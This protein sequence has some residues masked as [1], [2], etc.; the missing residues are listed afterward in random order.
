M[1]DGSRVAGRFLVA[2]ALWFTTGCGAAPH[3][4]V[5]SNAGIERTDLNALLAAYPLAPADIIRA[6]PLGRTEAL[7]YHLVQIRDREQPHVHAT[8]DLTV[9]LLRGTGVLHVRGTAQEMRAG[10][11]AA[12]PRDTPHYFVN[13]GSTPAIAFATFAP[14]YDGHDQIVTRDW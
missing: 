12:I 8:H 13:T 9:T 2:C 10:D 3:L 7:S 11:T 6:V 14:P 1:H 4:I 5:P